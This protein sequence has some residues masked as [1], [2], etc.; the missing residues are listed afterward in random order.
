MKSPLTFMLILGFITLTCQPHPPAVSPKNLSI[1]YIA[2]MGVLLEY[3]EQTVLL[4]GL[5][6]EYG[7]DYAFPSEQGWSGEL[8]PH[9]PQ[10]LIY[11]LPPWCDGPHIR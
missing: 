4:G 2:N 3:H 8:V 7:P 9:G 6:E 5:H 11:E 1:T 10:M